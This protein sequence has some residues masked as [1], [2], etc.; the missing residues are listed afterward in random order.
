VA[1]A[2]YTDL[3]TAVANWLHRSDL[4]TYVPDFIALGETRVYRE[5]RI[6]AMEVALSQAIASGVIAIPSAYVELKH[7][8]V[9]GSPVQILTRKNAAWIHENYPTRS[10]DGK[11]KFIAS[12]AGNFIF[13]PFPDSTYTVKGTYYSRLTALSDSNTTNWFTTNSPGIL[14]FAALSEAEPFLRNDPRI[15]LWQ[16]KYDQ[17][18]DGIMREERDEQF[19]GSPLTMSVSKA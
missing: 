13:G 18:K 19:S 14:L 1:I 4:T 2:T 9:D 3:K 7:A 10:S 16:A 12:D 8:Y 6:R 17:E 11:P 5:L 15:E